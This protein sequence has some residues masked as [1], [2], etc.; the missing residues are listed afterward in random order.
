MEIEQILASDEFYQWLA[1]QLLCVRR[2]DEDAKHDAILRIWILIKRRSLGQIHNI[3][4]FLKTQSER[5]AI[6]RYRNEMRRRKREE[7]VRRNRSE[8]SNDSDPIVNFE[9]IEECEILR[10]RLHD[11]MSQLDRKTRAAIY[12]QYFEKLSI[13]E[14]AE[15]ISEKP[16]NVKSLIHRGKLQ[17]KNKLTPYYGSESALEAA[18]LPLAEGIGL[19]KGGIVASRAGRIVKSS[20]WIKVAAVILAVVGVWLS[21]PRNWITDRLSLA[22]A[23]ELASSESGS[24]VANVYDNSFGPASR[25]LALQAGKNVNKS[26]G[27]YIVH[28]LWSR[29]KTPAVGVWIPLIPMNVD[30]PDEYRLRKC[31]QTDGTGTIVIEGEDML[32]YGFPAY[33]LPLNDLSNL[34]IVGEQTLE[35]T[36]EIICSGKR[37]DLE[38]IV[39]NPIGQPIAGAKIYRK[40]GEPTYDGTPYVEDCFPLD[41]T[42]TD[43]KFCIRE[44]SGCAIRA[45]A[46][47]YSPSLFYEKGSILIESAY[48]ISSARGAPLPERIPVRLCLQPSLK[49]GIHGKVIA[50]DQSPVV[51][52]IIRVWEDPGLDCPPIAAT[53]TTDANG[54][55]VTNEM[56]PGDWY[57]VLA[58]S[59]RLSS[60]RKRIEVKANIITQVQIQLC[61]TKIL[62]KV[63]TAKGTPA[64]AAEID[65]DFGWGYFNAPRKYTVP[66]NTNT[67]GEF[68]LRPAT[69]ESSNLTIRMKPYSHTEEI[70]FK[71][72]ETDNFFY[73]FPEINTHSVRGRLIDPSGNPLVQKCTID[74][75]G[76]DESIKLGYAS[77][78]IAVDRLG[79]F[80]I[81]GVPSRIYK[82]MITIRKPKDEKSDEK[83]VRSSEITLSD[84]EILLQLTE[85]ELKEFSR[86][87]EESEQSDPELNKVIDINSGRVTGIL[88]NS[89]GSPR[90]A[91]VYV[92]AGDEIVNYGFSDCDTGA[93][94]IQDVKPGEYQ[95]SFGPYGLERL[96]GRSFTLE[97]GQTY[98]DGT[99]TFPG[100]GI[101]N[102]QCNRVGF[103]DGEQILACIIRA[104]ISIRAASWEDTYC[105][106]RTVRFLGD[107]VRFDAWEGGYW[108]YLYSLDKDGRVVVNNTPSPRYVEVCAGRE[109]PIDSIELTRMYKYKIRLEYPE[110]LGYSLPV[111]I[112]KNISGEYEYVR[113]C[114]AKWNS[115]ESA[116]NSIVFETINNEES[117]ALPPGSY[118]FQVAD[119]SYDYVASGEFT[120]S[121]IDDLEKNTSTFPLTIKHAPPPTEEEENK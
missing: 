81:D 5:A 118:Y 106:D 108:L 104:E 55:F 27:K 65:F 16:G 80:L 109:T 90:A 93:F 6:D 47:G 4:G 34:Q 22:D 43:G 91:A 105:R 70:H 92:W 66:I 20:N 35:K 40:P 9:K 10:R 30:G 38:G 18:L 87:G 84:T 14:I 113:T 57:S 36:V 103:R 111:Y 99:F 74:L 37:M 15:K 19:A 31:L 50:A 25:K 102:I 67:E 53:Y 61:D 45:C 2:D 72:C 12:L 1:Q 60:L 69:A 120:V 82:F 58:I 42:D 78:R 68:E 28:F 101:V 119:N 44:W 23:R 89:D 51:N 46:E 85:E 3:R 79:N 96:P 7:A 17:L 33:S 29:D 112:W 39:V 56:E 54:E 95:L 115:K 86:V 8:G 59:D 62:G 64:Q 88:N 114:T 24:T 41:I 83:L 77:D 13:H 73:Q 110:D 75:T 11:A 32:M 94:I 63:V 26:R 107:K 49:N 21:L 98:D 97:P 48:A 52:A 100:R 121:A 116:E 76:N 117:L 71:Q